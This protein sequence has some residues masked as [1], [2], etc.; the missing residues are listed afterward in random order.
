MSIED[1]IGFNHDIRALLAEAMA[2]GEINLGCR[3]TLV[4]QFCPQGFKDNIAA[5]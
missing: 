4:T 1:A 2:S 3:H 5:T